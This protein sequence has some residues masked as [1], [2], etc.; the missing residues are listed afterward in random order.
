MSAAPHGSAG[1]RGSANLGATCTGATGPFQVA[2]HAENVGGPEAP[3]DH[4]DRRCRT[5]RKMAIWRGTGFR[6]PGDAR[7][8]LSDR[9]GSADLQAANRAGRVR[10]RAHAGPSGPS[11]GAVRDCETSLL[12][13]FRPRQVAGIAWFAGP[14]GLV[15]PPAGGEPTISAEDGG[16]LAALAAVTSGRV[17]FR[18]AAARRARRI[19]RRR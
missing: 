7:P 3:Q 1:P 5:C 2:R 19:H 4:R 17:S 10:D 14:G 12:S 6:C 13:R 15:G 16:R 18:H 11:F 8:V 9:S